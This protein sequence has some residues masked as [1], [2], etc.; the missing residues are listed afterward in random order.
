MR[1]LPFF[2]RGWFALVLVGIAAC[3]GAV[4]FF[5]IDAA[6]ISNELDYRYFLQL[7]LC[8]GGITGFAA[9]YFARLVAT[10]RTSWFTL[11]LLLSPAYLFITTLALDKNPMVAALVTLVAAFILLMVLLANHA[12]RK[13]H[14]VLSRDNQRE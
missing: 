3:A 7:Y 2:C 1:S 13:N 8:I 6:D 5:A 9:W 12:N 10:G 4:W 11:M 14:A